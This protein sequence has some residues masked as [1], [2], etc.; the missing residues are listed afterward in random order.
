MPDRKSA[1]SVNSSGYE[2]PV[3][4]EAI[5]AG[6]KALQ[7]L[8]SSGQAAQAKRQERVLKKLEEAVAKEVQKDSAKP[9]EAGTRR[10]DKPKKG[11]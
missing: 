6:P 1:T 5:A 3:L 2:N 8:T 7:Q 10:T 4:E 11:E 9:S